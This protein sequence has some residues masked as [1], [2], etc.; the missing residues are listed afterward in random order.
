M[1]RRARVL[2]CIPFLV[3]ALFL[4][5][6]ISYSLPARQEP[7]D[8][9]VR[10]V[11]TGVDYL[12]QSLIPA[13]TVYDGTLVGGLSAITYDPAGDVYYVLSDDRSEHQPARFYSMTFDLSGGMLTSAGTAITGVTTLT[14]EAGNPFAFNRI[15]PEGI[16]YSGNGGLY[17]SSEGSPA[18]PPFVA[19]F[20]TDGRMTQS[21][22]LPAKFLPAGGTQGARDNL[23]F[24]SLTVRPDG[25]YLF[26]AVENAL[27]QDGPIAGLEQG[28]AS[29]VILF[30]RATGQGAAEFVYVTEPVAGE[31]V[32][33]GGERQNGLAE[34]L[35]LD[36]D[37][38]LLALE[39]SYS[40]GMGFTI[41]LF[42][43]R[44]QHALDAAPV[45]SLVWQGDALYQLDAPVHKK[46]VV[47]LSD[48]GLPIITNIEGMTF[49]PVLPDGRQSL[50]LVA[51]NNFNSF[52]PTQFIAL[53]LTIETIPT[54]R[55]ALESPRALDQAV[56][57]AGDTAGRAAAPAIW[58]HPDDPDQSLVIA[59]LAGGGLQLLDLSGQPVQTIAPATYGER[60]FSDVDL[61]YNFVL[62][63]QKVDLAVVSD[64]ANDTPAIYRLDP[65][66]RQLVDVTAANFPQA[67]FDGGEQAVKGVAT[68]TSPVSGRA[69]AF[70]AQMDG[71]QIAQ[72]E[73]SD[74][75]AGGVTAVVVR[76]LQLPAAGA[77]ASGM[78][79]DRLRANLFVATK[80]GGDILKYPAEPDGGTG[81]TLIQLPGAG[82]PEV[83]IA[84]LAIYYASGET[85]YLLASSRGDH[86]YAL[87]DR[88]GAHAY[89]GRFAA[90]AQGDVDQATGT[91]GI[92]VVNTPLGQ[93]FPGGLLV[94]QDSH[95]E[96]QNVIAADGQLANNST[97]FKYVSWPAVA[98]SFDAPL[99]IDSD[100]F[101]PRRPMR[102]LLP[103]IS[104]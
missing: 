104:R 36:N 44:T 23:S 4:L 79:A 69:Y 33:A 65:Q 72:L 54:A 25:R 20:G 98:E 76:T 59:T 82:D 3:A 73:L 70:V 51:D 86:S 24:E 89:L 28:S 6:G 1:N 91:T 63:G 96:P 15:D 27:A 48:L 31:P 32:P 93:S 77:R 84:G 17:V 37:G 30:D 45:D 35:A 55:P 52:L 50:L 92:A 87:F 8:S 5:N 26:T 16:A 58:L 90:G 42:T 18:A 71:E 14:D 7:A 49:G 34:L 94:V 83:G 10:K 75:G 21:L 66:A 22:A 39:R 9:P 67:L 56:P 53:A 88:A 13:G 97:N 46:L 2:F 12:G 19:A 99:L 61:I 100:G 68:Y 11:V 64:S 74:D 85:G 95:D 29:R 81:H 102:L 47:D 40:E 41:R 78:A 101:E 103:T 43:A 80:N 57:P 60:R 38:T 62:A